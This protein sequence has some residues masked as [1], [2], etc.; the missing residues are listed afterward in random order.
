MA[1]QESFSAGLTR[2]GMLRAGGAGLGVLSLAAATQLV[3]AH[4]DHQTAP[5]TPGE[6]PPPPPATPTPA[7]QEQ[8]DA[9]GAAGD[10]TVT[11]INDAQGVTESVMLEIPPIEFTGEATSSTLPE[12]PLQYIYRFKDSAVGAPDGSQVPFQY[13]E[14]DW[15]T[16][17]APRGPNGSFSSAHFDFHF[18]MWPQEQVEAELTCVSSNGKTC[19]EFL[20]DYSQMQMFQDMPESKYIPEGYRADVG[21]AIPAMGLHLLDMTQVYSVEAV[22]HYPVL[23]YGTFQGT[24]MFAEASVTL[25]TL[26]DAMVAEGNRISFPFR[27]PEAFQ[28]DIDWP[29]EFVIE[30][31]PDTGGF[32]VGFEGFT[33]QQA[34]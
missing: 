28:Q 8:M 2:R 14:V 15:N 13:V 22:N 16:E 5:A 26:Q 1:V 25:F 29:T 33:R 11:Q 6:I 12:G 4:G 17:G 10:F 19:D 32:I 18:Y 3:A 7:W 31:L 34:G 21:S 27:Q 24:V 9:Y 20:T 30:Y 23:I